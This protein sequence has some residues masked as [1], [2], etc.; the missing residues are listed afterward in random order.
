MKRLP[1]LFAPCF[2]PPGVLVLAVPVGPALAKTGL[3]KNDVILSVNGEKTANTAALLR[4]APAL[5]AGHS[6]KIEIFR[7]QEELILQL[8]P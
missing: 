3:Q 5:P 7:N 6:A 4:L 8:N 1:K 2:T